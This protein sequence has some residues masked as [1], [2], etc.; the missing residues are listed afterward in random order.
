MALIVTYI[1]SVASSAL[2]A[3]LLIGKYMDGL[4]QLVLQSMEESNDITETTN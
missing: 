4:G 1:I 2:V 3:R